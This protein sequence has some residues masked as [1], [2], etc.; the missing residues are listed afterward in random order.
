MNIV[1]WMLAGAI[2]GWIGFS[3]LRF[4]E[5]RGLLV[6]AIIGAGGGLLGGKLIEPMFMDPQA[7]AGA[8]STSGLVFAAIVAAG[9]LAAGNL[10]Q[11]RWGV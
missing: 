11:N 8:F 10:I 9:A 7:V 6:S 2:V 3:Y 5:E 4:N 1:M